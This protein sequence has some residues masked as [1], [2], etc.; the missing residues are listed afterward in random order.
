MSPA[1]WARVKALVMGRTGHRCE[2][3][4]SGAE[5]S[6]GLWLEAHERWSYDD[7]ARVRTLRRLVCLCTRC[8]RTTHFG[9]AEVT[10]QGPQAHAHLRAVNQ[11]ECHRR[12]RPHRHG[13]QDVAGPVGGGLVV[14]PGRPHRR[15]RRP[16]PAPTATDRRAIAEGT[17]DRTIHDTP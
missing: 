2:V 14:G 17:L 6:H 7:A 4:G 5:P 16:S 13:R 3:C 12:R 8:H 15:R 11:V 10:G 1:D 9:F